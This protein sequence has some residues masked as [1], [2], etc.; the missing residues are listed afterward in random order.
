MFVRFAKRHALA[1]ILCLFGASGITGCAL[2]TGDAQDDEVGEAEQALPTCAAQCRRLYYAC[3]ELPDPETCADDY[4]AC[5][6]AC[7]NP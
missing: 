7:N 3:L 4:L 1:S 6:D 2:G 5:L